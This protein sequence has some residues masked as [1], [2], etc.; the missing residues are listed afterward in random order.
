MTAKEQARELLDQ[1]PD[2]ATLDDILYEFY[3]HSKIV[4]GIA[5]IEAGRTV[6]QEEIERE[7]LK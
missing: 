3:V 5:D 6:S 2:E 1:L 4:R 7:F